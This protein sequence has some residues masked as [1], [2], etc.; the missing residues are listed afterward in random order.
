MARYPNQIIVVKI[1]GSVLDRLHPTFYTTC[2][3]LIKKGVFPII[4]HGGGP[5]ITQWMKRVG[6]EP[7]FIEG[8]RVT[9][10]ESLSIVTAVLGGKMNKQLVSAFTKI[11]AYAVGLSGI[12]LQLLSVQPVD[13]KLGYVGEVTEVHEKPILSLLKFGW[14][15][16]IA[17]LGADPKGQ[18][19]NVNAD[20]AAAAIAKTVGAK[21]LFMV[22]DVEGVLNEKGEILKKITP[23]LIQYYIEAKQITGGMIPKVRAGMSCLQGSVEEVMI[24]DGRKPWNDQLENIK[25]TQLIKEEVDSDVVVSKLSSL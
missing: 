25:G 20:E 6:K 19:F 13:P 22:S 4:V 23:S 11:G 15:P 14:I 17:S 10:Q 5:A 3:H 16:V 7:L 18:L 1:G 21:K 8:R 24:V 12:D 2:Q 9:D